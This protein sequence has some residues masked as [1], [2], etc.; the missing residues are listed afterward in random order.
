MQQ[1]AG[2]QGCHGSAGIARAASAQPAPLP[3]PCPVPAAAGKFSSISPGTRGAAAAGGAFPLPVPPHLPGSPSPTL[4]PHSPKLGAQSKAWDPGVTSSTEQGRPPPKKLSLGR[5]VVFFSSLQWEQCQSPAP[6]GDAVRAGLL[7]LPHPFPELGT[8]GHTLELL[9]VTQH[10][11]P[12]GL[13]LQLPTILLSE[14][15][16]FGTSV[17]PECL[18]L[19]QSACR[20]A[21]MIL[22]TTE[23]L[24]TDSCCAHISGLPKKA[25]LKQFSTLQEPSLRHLNYSCACCVTASAVSWRHCNG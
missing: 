24:Q 9:L 23:S 6:L 2:P 7:L 3:P 20:K 13:V 5:F 21:L 11:M 10:T 15:S 17:P 16:G 19:W 22:T 1:L 14:D 4:T 25:L 18:F 12:A 8:L